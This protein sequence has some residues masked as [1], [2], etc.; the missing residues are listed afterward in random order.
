M[1]GPAR[2][3]EAVSHLEDKFQVSQHR[4]NATGATPAE[5]C[6]VVFL[7]G[8]PFHFLLGRT[9]LKPQK[10]NSL[11]QTTIAC[12]TKSGAD[13]ADFDSASYLL[14]KMTITMCV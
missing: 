11:P 13:Q 14:N 6:V 12:G 9:P 7:S 4:W 2:K 10:I 8:S 3:R 1:V 5:S